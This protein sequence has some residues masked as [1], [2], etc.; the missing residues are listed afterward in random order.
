MLDEEF[1]S[2]I[3]SRVSS[4][5][6]ARRLNLRQIRYVLYA[7]AIGMKRQQI[8]EEL[9]I[10]AKTISNL[11]SKG[12]ADPIVLLT[13]SFVVEQTDLDG[14]WHRFLCRLCGW[15]FTES[16]RCIDHAAEHV[17][18]GRLQE[19]HQAFPYAVTV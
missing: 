8:A 16:G 5:K 19:M 18:P 9:K 10:P 4:S 6:A 3:P 15:W 13:C 14:Q 17:W 11:L 2:A 7:R 1:A 12:K